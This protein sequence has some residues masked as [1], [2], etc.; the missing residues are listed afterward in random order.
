MRGSNRY[1]WICFTELHFN[2]W[3]FIIM[4]P[5]KFLLY[6]SDWGMAVPEVVPSLVLGWEF[7]CREVVITCTSQVNSS[8]WRVRGAINPLIRSLT[9]SCVNV[10]N[11]G[12]SPSTF[13]DELLFAISSVQPWLLIMRSVDLL[14]PITVFKLSVI[15][16]IKH[17]SFKT[18]I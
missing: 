13:S 16:G 18:W 17:P 7:E 12:T 10:C 3:V 1:E 4:K 9:I 15:S 5:T 11:S 6:L 14:I 8:S 2:F